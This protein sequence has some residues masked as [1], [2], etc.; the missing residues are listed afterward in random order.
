M[1]G[2][3]WE[4]GGGRWEV[5]GG[6]GDGVM[7]LDGNGIRKKLHDQLIASKLNLPDKKDNSK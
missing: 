6:R 5:G 4:V 3:R 1:G 2:G 7:Q